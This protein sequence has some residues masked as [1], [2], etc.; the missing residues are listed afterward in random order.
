MSLLAGRHIAVLGAP[1]MGTSPLADAL[2]QALP[3]HHITEQLHRDQP[4]DLALVLGLDLSDKAVLGPD[5]HAALERIDTAIRQQLL[6]LSV[7]YRVVYGSTAS[8]RLNQALLALG[9][10][11][12]DL[13]ARTVREQ[14]QYQLNRGRTPWSCDTCS[15]PD[16]EHRLFTGLINRPK[17]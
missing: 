17:L 9:L 14:A 6:T 3:G 12:M 7:P 11:S 5:E 2:R 13:A 16:C 4:P 1:G 8:E 10:P 15:D